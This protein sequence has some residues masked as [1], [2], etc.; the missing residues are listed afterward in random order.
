MK[1]QISGGIVLSFLSQAISII[2]G[3][4]YT[5]YMIRA[6]GQNEYGL[7]QLVLS[8]V[9]YLNLMNLGFNGAYIRYF[10][11]AKTE[12]DEDEVANVNGM[13]MK[14]FLVITA[15][16]L[17]AG[18]ILYFNIGILG[19]Q[20]TAAD[21]VTA[22]KLLVI[23]VVNL[24][25]S[26]PNS[27]FVA[28]MSANERFVYQKAVGIALNIAIPILNIPLL[29]LG[30][31]SVGVVSASLC[32]TVVRLVL[33]VLYCIKKLHIRI[34]IKFFNKGIF[35]ELL[36]YTFF[37]FLSDIVDQL[38][39]NVDK[40]LLGRILGTVPVAI[41]SVGY[42][43]KNY[44][45]I[46]SWIVPEMFV[47]QANRMAIE[48]SDDREL[49]QI[50][51]KVG[52]FNNYLM[53]L[54]LSGFF[55]VGRQ[56]ITLWVGSE[57]DTA[58]FVSLILMLSGYI[59]AV[60]TLG[61]N[62]QN[63]K[64]MHRTRSVVYFFVAC[65][66]VAASVPLIKVLGVVGTSIGTMVAT[67]LGHGIFM[68]WYYHKKIG[69]DIPYFW[70]EMFKWIVPVCFLSVLG[71]IVVHRLNINTWFRIFVFVCGYSLIY[72]I[73]LFFVGFNREQKHMA[74]MKIKDILTNMERAE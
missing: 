70:K 1:K 33:N 47:P 63:A 20:L 65:I 54:V 27:L 29:Y 61:V 41:Y 72:V 48:C 3:L 4:V 40:F 49:T 22:R 28:F 2:V 15:L 59:P 7:Y 51:T 14:V 56:F 25:I 53:L 9:N 21:Y 42:N 38:N 71:F 8:V 62:I 57:Y 16:C 44:Y 39:S 55:L 73:L 18:V 19:E 24:A 69:L 43:L 35:W 12:K 52:K 64:N 68:N 45:T 36:G 31:G 10:V 23:M 66:N 58:Y 60:Q 34:N 30:F 74:K 6:L 37:I 17:C 5:P 67:L 32:L 26:F 11:I 46:I 13:F 50:F